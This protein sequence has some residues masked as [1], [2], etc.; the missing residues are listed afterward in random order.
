MENDLQEVRAWVQQLLKEIQD[1]NTQIVDM[2]GEL[3]SQIDDVRAHISRN[4]QTDNDAA[5]NIDSL[6][7]AIDATRNEVNK[8]GGSVNQ[9]SSQVKEIRNR[10]R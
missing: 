10:I 2:R 8:L 9:I 4:D 7:G 3:R 1:V 6:R 5:R